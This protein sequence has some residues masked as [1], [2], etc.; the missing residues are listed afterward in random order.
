MATVLTI[1]G[2]ICLLMIIAI[3]LGCMIFTTQYFVWFHWKS[4]KHC[5]HT[6]EYKGLGEDDGNGH[7]L[8]HCPKCGARENI[9][10]EEFF[11]EVDKGF[12]PND[13]L[14]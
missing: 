2:F 13:N 9:P 1:I 6:M 3:L 8:F 14:V 4:C 5:G 10:R 11:R 7:Y 12:N